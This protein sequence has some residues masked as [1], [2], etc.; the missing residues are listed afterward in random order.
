MINQ[1]A[2]NE[3]QGLVGEVENQLQRILQGISRHLDTIVFEN[4]K[5]AKSQKEYGENLVRLASLQRAIRT[6]EKES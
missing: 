4:S 3:L 1:E 2:I 5:I 6:L